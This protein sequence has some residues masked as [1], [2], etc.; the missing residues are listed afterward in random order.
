VVPPDDGH[1][2]ETIDQEVHE[3][4]PSVPVELRICLFLELRRVY[5]GAVLIDHDHAQGPK[6]FLHRAT[7]AL[8]NTNRSR[9]FS[10]M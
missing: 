6:G 7:V 9:A 5:A 8:P 1:R 3:G 4:R 2:G 10:Q